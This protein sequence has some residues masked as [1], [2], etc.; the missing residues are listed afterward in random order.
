MNMWLNARAKLGISLLTLTG[1]PKA[2]PRAL[3]RSALKQRQH[4]VTFD[5]ARI[6]MT[7]KCRWS[8]NTASTPAFDTSLPAKRLPP[9]IPVPT[10]FSS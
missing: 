8:S 9:S 1:G 5:G 10:I 4:P 7:T 3:R 6:D 2:I